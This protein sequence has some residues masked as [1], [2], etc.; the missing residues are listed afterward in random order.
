MTRQVR[1]FESSA[2]T[3]ESDRG[4]TDVVQ[5]LPKFRVRHHHVDQA[6]VLG[7]GCTWQ[8]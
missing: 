4:K 3:E 6:A 8:A 5:P 7:T 1:R 2:S